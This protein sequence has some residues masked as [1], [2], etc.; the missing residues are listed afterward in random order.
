MIKEEYLTV[1][2]VL[3]INNNHFKKR[4]DSQDIHKE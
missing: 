2:T 1:Y 4:M 3:Q